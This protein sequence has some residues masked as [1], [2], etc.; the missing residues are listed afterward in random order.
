MISEI[1]LGRHL[2]EGLKKI[3]RHF[4]LAITGYKNLQVLYDRSSQLERIRDYLNK[5]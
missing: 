4:D 5:P 3:L 2:K 1:G